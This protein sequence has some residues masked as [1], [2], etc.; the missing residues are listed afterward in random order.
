M[1]ARNNAAYQPKSL[2][3]M[4]NMSCWTVNCS[5]WFSA[6]AAEVEVGVVVGVVVSDVAD[7]TFLGA[8]A[9]FST[10]AGVGFSKGS[11]GGAASPISTFQ[12]E[13]EVRIFVP[14][15]SFASTDDEEKEIAAEPDFYA[16]N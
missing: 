14:L 1:I 7:A 15:P 2:D 8:G 10:G 16:R 12:G 5:P 11:G 13:A 9:G 3:G 4:P 6:V